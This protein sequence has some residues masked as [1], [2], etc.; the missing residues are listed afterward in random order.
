MCDTVPLRFQMNI[1]RQIWGGIA[2]GKL[3]VDKLLVFRQD[4]ITSKR[5]IAQLTCIYIQYLSTREPLD[6]TLNSYD[7]CTLHKSKQYGERLKYRPIPYL[8]AE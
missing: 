2:I 7:G 5:I 8:G 6:L 1:F 4:G 3:L